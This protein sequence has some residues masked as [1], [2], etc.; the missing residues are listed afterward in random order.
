MK[1]FTDFIA[2]LG[3]MPVWVSLIVCPAAVVAAAV[4]FTLFGGRKA[5]PALAVAIG[6]A[7]IALVSTKFSAGET[8]AYFGLFSALSA[9]LSLLFLFPTV[10]RAAKRKGESREERI[11]R[12]FHEE[13]REDIPA[14]LPPKV[15]CFEEAPAPAEESGMRLSYVTTLIGKLTKCRLTPA[16]RLEVDVLDRSVSAYRGKALSESEL[17]TLNDCLASV[18]KLTAKYQL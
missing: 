12:K 5:Y 18:L 13:L 9:L 3:G 6:G 10:K 14:Q 1:G 2:L 16:D 7:G 4:L 11:Y 17:S 15:N 8:L